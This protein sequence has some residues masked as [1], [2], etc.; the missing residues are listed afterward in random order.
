MS[1]TGMGG[2]QRNIAL[3]EQLINW[4]FPFASRIYCC[5]VGVGLHWELWQNTVMINPCLSEEEHLF[6]Y[7][8]CLVLKMDEGE[9]EP[10]VNRK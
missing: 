2:H 6:N 7:F 3:L 9:M 10:G 1:A 5:T 8:C 4:L